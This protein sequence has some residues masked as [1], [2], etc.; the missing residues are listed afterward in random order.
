MSK[1]LIVSSYI[2]IDDEDWNEI[3][4]KLLISLKNT[5]DIPYSVL[6]TFDITLEDVSNDI[7]E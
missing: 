1:Q 6:K 3:L 4:D 7:D 5:V 2:D